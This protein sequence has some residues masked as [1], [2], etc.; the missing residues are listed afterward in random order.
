M[1]DDEFTRNVRRG[2]QLVLFEGASQHSAAKITGVHRKTLKR[3]IHLYSGISRYD[4]KEVQIDHAGAKPYLNDVSLSALRLFSLAM[5]FNDYTITRESLIEKIRYLHFLEQGVLKLEDVPRPSKP[6]ITRII[7][8]LGIPIKSLRKGA[9]VDMLRST[10]A[11][12][13]YLSD[14]FGKLG[15]IRTKYR[16]CAKNIWNADE[17][18]VSFSN[19]IL[20]SVTTRQCV[21]V[22]LT[23]DHIT[24]LVTSN[25]TGVQLQ[26]YLIFPG[27][28]TSDIPN[29]IFENEEVW[30][31]FSPSGWM[32]T[33][34]FQIWMLKFIMEVKNRKDEDEN[35]YTLL[36]VDGHNSRLNVNTMFT[37]AVNRI[38]VLVGPSHLTNAWQANDSGVNKAFKENLKTNVCL[39]IETKH[40]IS[41]SDVAIMIISALQKENMV[42]AIINSYKHVGI[43]PFDHLRMTKMI[44]AEK[45]REE[46]L[47]D[48]AVSLAVSL[49]KEHLNTLDNLVAEKRKRDEI[50]KVKKKRKKVGIN[51]SYACVLTNAENL[52]SL[53]LGVQYT[54]LLKLKAA[55]LHQ[56]MIELGWTLSQIQKPGTNKFLTM[57]ELQA[58]VLKHLESLHEAQTKKIDEEVKSRL[59]HVPSL[60]FSHCQTDAPALGTANTQN[61]TASMHIITDE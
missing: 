58:M 12:I 29:V 28:S 16:I 36:I 17:V 6:T 44:Q 40:E 31:N 57:K 43:E 60:I 56:Q 8:N 37:A 11:N 5:D 61:D 1:V 20:K 3:Y 10:K 45:P 18:G 26:P 49:C 47:D 35:E 22:N 52:S 4:L 9:G 30:A 21:R 15:D 53:Q 54:T 25:A 46:L 59:S 7:S 41:N 38:I 34:R 13:E 19:F 24:T 55:E 42:P 50:E 39:Q 2:L 32:D 51:T 33:E 14:W 48:P 23:H 27:L